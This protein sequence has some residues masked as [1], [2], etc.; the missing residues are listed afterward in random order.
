MRKTLLLARSHLRKAKG[1]TI[2]IVVLILLAAAMLNIW[3]MLAMDYKQN[4]DRYHDKLNAEHV[5]L[6]LSSD[7]AGLRDYVSRILDEDERTAEYCM[8]DSLFM[9]GSFPYNGGEVNTNIVILEKQAADSRTIGRIEIVEDSEYTSGIYLP[10]IYGTSGEYGIG[11]TIEIMVGSNQV[12]YTICGFINSV[13]LGSHNCSMAEV[14]LTPDC[15]QELEERGYA[16]KATLVS[17]RLNDRTENENYEA[18]LNVISEKYPNVWTISNSYALVAQSRYISQM[19]CSGIVSAMAFFVLLIALVIIASNLTNYIQENMRNFGALKA[20][21]Y[22]SGQLMRS[23]LLQ[24]L[25]ISMIAALTGAGLSYCIFPAVNS[26]MVAQTGIPYTVHFLPLPLLCTFLILGGVVALTVWI[27]SRR[28]KKTDPIVALRQGVQTHSFKRNHVPLEKTQ[29][30][31]H[32]A[33]ALKITI[34]GMKQ[35][36]I[37]CITMF[38]LSLVVVFSGVIT[39]NVI[40]DMSPFVNLIIGETA[41]SCID[42]NP[43]VEEDFLREMREDE[44]VEKVYLFIQLGVEHVGEMQLFPSI[45]DDFADLNNQDLVFEGRFPRYDNEIAIAAKYAKEKGLKMGSE[46]TLSAEGKEAVYIICGFTQ[47]SNWLGKD[48]LLTRSGYERMSALQHC[49]Y[50]L[51]L[52]EGT[53]IDEFNEEIKERYGSD[54]NTAMNIQS[55]LEGTSSVYVS[56]MTIIVI[57]VL[58]LSVIIIVFVLYLLARTLLNDKKSYYGI[59]KALGFTTR[60]LILQTALSFMPAMVFSTIVG[61]TVCSFIINPLTALFLRGIGVVKCTFA[62]PVDFISTIGI[63]LVLF[64]FGAVCLLSL[65]IRKIAPETLL[66][67]E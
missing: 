66:T 12:S 64:A 27:S 35:N 14:L 3:L 43:G 36:F 8:E 18:M 50:Y 4:F 54:I 51:N 62:V 59:L 15:Y 46:I 17:I 23:L 9:V 30:P 61:L 55:I 2:A 67:G 20:L 39:E 21:G 26:M 28:I 49:S 58:V 19:I 22:T 38:V 63:G 44:R 56:L 11:E 47:I 10:M 48:C 6:A 16:P 52:R 41:D 42:V 13:M 65:K 32:F 60:Q 1:Q 25:G 31:L 29:A 34:S 24:F 7:D 53:D 5:T 33:L 45:T 57:A 37:V 40:A